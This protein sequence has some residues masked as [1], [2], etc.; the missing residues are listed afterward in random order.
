MSTSWSGKSKSGL[1]AKPKIAKWVIIIT[2]AI[3]F[4]L[5]YK[6]FDPDGGGYFPQCPFHALTG[7]Q[8]PGCGSQRAIHYLLNFDLKSAF[9]MNGLLIAAIPYIL[10]AAVFDFVK[11]RDERLLKLKK[12]LFGRPAL[13][14]VFLIV[15]AFFI[16][17]NIY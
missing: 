16:L 9:A 14:I 7:W 5:L 10:L 1:E 3:V 4:V 8:C 17:R 15:I 12:V 6:I 13:F 11:I 2:V